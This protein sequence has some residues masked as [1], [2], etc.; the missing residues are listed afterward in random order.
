MT[1][2][3]YLPHADLRAEAAI[4]A[5]ALVRGEERV[6]SRLVAWGVADLDPA[7]FWDRK[8][9]EFWRA[10]RAIDA[11][12]EA[13]NLVA[14]LAEMRAAGTLRIV[15]T[16]YQI[17]IING[18]PAIDDRALAGYVRVV[19]EL[20]AKRRTREAL[21]RVGAQLFEGEVED[22]ARE[23]E[24]TG[25]R[26]RSCAPTGALTSAGEV[27]RA[28]A[29]ARVK[30][31]TGFA[32]LDL[33]LRGGIPE[34]R[35][36][37]LQGPPGVAKTGLV[38]Q[39]G[40]VAAAAGFAVAILAA[41]EDAEG[42]AIRL[43]QALGAASRDELEAVDGA[44]AR[45]AAGDRLARLPIWL[46]DGERPDAT[47]E[48]VSAGLARQRGDRPSLLVVDSIQT[49]RA[50][51]SAEADGPRA[52]V[53]LVLKALKSQ[54]RVHR[55][56]VLATSEVSRGRYRARARGERSSALAS[57][58]ESG[59]IEYA[60]A[61]LL[62]LAGVPDL[63]GQIDVEIAKNRLGAKDLVFRLRQDFARC[64][65]TEIERPDDPPSDAAPPLGGRPLEDDLARVVTAW[66]DSTVN[67]VRGLREF[68]RDR[69]IALGNA[70][71][72]EVVDRLGV[73]EDGADPGARV[74]NDGS[75]A[76]PR[77]RLRGAS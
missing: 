29:P 55:H 65:F 11:R 5:C 36:G 33:A 18:A 63:P 67:G 73:D 41:D 42:L 51:G 24:G 39:F 2:R 62:D 74:V 9:V 20:A 49:V 6:G 14:V 13:I 38:C 8:H 32:T 17:E 40:L 34:G 64:T 12:D 58:K 76:R 52:R 25:A 50:A 16:D 22:L 19:R 15:P 59:G 1:A 57:G 43:G 72:Q 75:S 60:A 23:L 66:G 35:L 44:V 30:L 3:R 31:A 70:R 37:V 61:V 48:Q 46:A 10:I 54:A 4:I 56:I 53:D 47:V 69:G 21:A 77:W 28:I 68:L 7:D 27:V 45:A 71:I 26:L